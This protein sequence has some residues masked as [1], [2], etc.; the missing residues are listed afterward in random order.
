MEISLLVE[1]LVGKSVKVVQETGLVHT[2]KCGK[3]THKALVLQDTDIEPSFVDEVAG[4]VTPVEDVDS[5]ETPVLAVAVLV[6]VEVSAVAGAEL[7]TLVDPVEPLVGN[8][9][10]V[11]QETGLVHTGKCGK[12]THK[13]L[14]LQDT[15]IEPAFVDEV[16]GEVTPVDDIGSVETPVLAV[17]VVDVLVEVAPVAGVELETL[18]LV[19]TV[20][21][22]VGNSVKVVQETGLVH[23]GKCGKLTH[24]ALV[25][26]DTEIEPA[27][28]DEV[29]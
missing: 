25:L 26:H 3:L 17:A 27:F 22:L 9:V 12:L 15:E 1:L 2:G 16:A 20:E 10:K 8:S 24:K 6:I 23:T 28:V 29:A 11:V 18:L 7:E 19:D 4:V 5:V 21:A 13:A 14:V